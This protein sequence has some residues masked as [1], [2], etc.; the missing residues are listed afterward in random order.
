M[1]GKELTRVIFEPLACA[2]N[3]CTQI[4][5]TG[6]SYLVKKI[7]CKNGLQFANSIQLG[8]TYSPN[9]SRALWEP[10]KHEKVITKKVE[11]YEKIY[12]P[13]VKMAKY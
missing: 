12:S 1:Y 11:T 10:V 6:I 7:K 8:G 4:N 3:V 9:H 5:N 2:L 13:S